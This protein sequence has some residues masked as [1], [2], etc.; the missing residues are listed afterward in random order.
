MNTCIS[1]SCDHLGVGRE[2][3]NI[4]PHTNFPLL[5][6][7]ENEED[8]SNASEQAGDDAN[9]DGETG[10]VSEEGGSAEEEG[11]VKDE[12][13]EPVTSGLSPLS[14]ESNSHVS[15][16]V[17]TPSPRDSP[18]QS[19]PMQTDN[20]TPVPNGDVASV[21]ALVDSSSQ[22]SDTLVSTSKFT[23]ESADGSPVAANGVS[24][25]PKVETCDTQT[26]NGTSPPPSSRTTRSLKRKREEST[27]EKPR[28]TK[29]IIIHDR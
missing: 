14:Y 24:E 1:N 21:E 8:D 3:Q 12:D 9:Q 11:S 2:K 18:S 25:P 20:Q 16:L 10:E 26:T 17:D 13:K 22:V 15:P 19:E 23:K 5:D 4:F 29:H 27:Q 28:K 6:D 7:E